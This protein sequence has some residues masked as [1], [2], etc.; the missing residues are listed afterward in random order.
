MNILRSLPIYSVAAGL[1]F[2]GAKLLS[3][4]LLATIPLATTVSLTAV[5]NLF[6]LAIA[7]YS[8]DPV[9]LRVPKPCASPA[10]VTDV[11]DEPARAAA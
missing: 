6:A 5:L 3:A 10:S 1:V 8:R 11:G 7:D 9:P 4:P 2:V